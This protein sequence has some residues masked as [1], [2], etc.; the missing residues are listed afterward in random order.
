MSGR[1][2]FVLSLAALSV[3][4]NSPAFAQLSGAIYTT[5]QSG[6]VVNGNL[7]PAKNHV[8][9]AGGPGPNAPCSAAGLPDG[10]YYFQVTDPS[11]STLLSTDAVT[12]REVVVSG[13]V[14]TA[15]T[16]THTKKTGPCGSKVIQLAP[17]ADTPNNGG[18]YKVW[19]TPVAQYDGSGAGF[20]GFLAK[21]SKTD[22][23]KIKGPGP[24][25]SQSIIQ[26]FKFFDFNVNGVW[27][28]GVPQEV[29]IAGWKVEIYKDGVLDGVA[30][31]DDVGEYT[32][33]RNL[34]GSAYLLRE[35]A[36]PP[37]FIPA[38]GARWLATR[39]VEGTVV[40]NAAIVPGPLF[41]NVYFEVALGV[42]RT[43]GFWH[44]E[45]ESLLAACD[46][47]WRSE[48]N[49]ACLRNNVSSADPLLSIFLVP[50]EPATFADA[51]AA[52][53]AYIV[54]DSALGHGGFIL[55]S[56]V[57]P[58]ILNNTCG[59]MPGT[60]YVD[61]L[62]NGVLVSLDSMLAGATALLC[63]PNAGLTGPDDP[64]QDLRAAMLNCVNEFAAINE[65]GDLTNPQPVNR[66]SQT[67]GIFESPY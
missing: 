63:D 10:N 8:Y 16:G 60:I 45:G 41:G 67:P 54:G 24:A 3:S 13:G 52:W 66:P 62:L 42:G 27:D 35:V 53:A 28:A 48:L 59:F 26:G 36:P 51:F 49:A 20:F 14:I 64:Y 29:P 33:I 50:E 57:A 5:N 37:G 34:D 11:G 2:R 58:T 32:F 44:N 22:N 46:P 7:Y 25:L 15:T 9:L 55:S 4:V 6:T 61:R 43:K 65:C 38:V 17:F 23:F 1:V 39:P 21:Y 19:M 56:Q 18:E 30:Y 47:L 40:A 12:N 31:T